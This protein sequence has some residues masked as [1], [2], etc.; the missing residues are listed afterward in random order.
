MV[1]AH[2]DLRK[3]TVSFYIYIFLVVLFVREFCISIF[4]FALLWAGRNSILFM[5][6]S[7][8]END[9]KLNLES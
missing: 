4:I 8:Q 2:M 6:A 7:T 3:Q 9:N 5:Y 1:N